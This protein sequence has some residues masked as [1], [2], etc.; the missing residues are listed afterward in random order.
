MAFAR[1]LPALVCGLGLAGCTA[2]AAFYACPEGCAAM[3]LPRDMEMINDCLCDAGVDTT[4]EEAAADALDSNEPFAC[5]GRYKPKRGA[6]A[7]QSAA[8]CDCFHPYEKDLATQECVLKSCPRAGN[9]EP[10]RGVG[11]VDSLADCTCTPPFVKVETSGQCVAGEAV[12][13]TA[14]VRGPYT[15]P[16]N[17]TPA[18]GVSPQ[19]FEDCHCTWGFV[20]NSFQEC[21]RE[22][23]AYVCPVNSAKRPDLPIHDRPR[24][25]FDC[26]CLSDD[27]YKRDE[28]AHACW[29]V[30]QIKQRKP[31]RRSSNRGAVEAEDEYQEFDVVNFDTQTFECPPFSRAVATVPHSI[32]Q[33]QCL[34][35]YAWKLPEMIC[36]R[37]SA[38]KCPEHA[39]KRTQT[40]G[41]EVEASFEDC[42]CARGYFL[43]SISQR[44]VPWML[45]NSNA[46]P[47]FAVLTQWPLQSSANCKCIYGLNETIYEEEGKARRKAEAQEVA[48]GGTVKDTPPMRHRK[49]E[50]NTRPTD[51]TSGDFSQCPHDS[52]ATTWPIAS[53]DDCACLADFEMTPLSEQEVARGVGDGFH[54]VASPEKAVLADEAAA[55]CRAPGVIHPLSGECRLP[56]EEIPAKK[57]SMKTTPEDKPEGVLF[58]GIEYDYELVDGTI[59]IIQG[60]I[61]IGERLVW[62]DK[63]PNDEDESTT[64]IEHVLHGYYNSGRDHRWPRDEL[65]FQVDKSARPFLRTIL[66]ATEHINHAT[67][68]KFHRCGG[69]NC[70]TDMRCRSHD[71]VVVQGVEASCYSFVGRIGG[72]QRLGVSADCGLGNVVHVLLHAVGLRHAVDREDR[73]EHVRIAWECVPESKR[74]YFVV[75]DM[76]LTPTPTNAADRVLDPPPYDLFSIMHHPVDAFVHSA[77]DDDKPLWCPSMIPLIKDDD[78]RLA[79]M[80]DMGQR[81]RMTTSDVKS[82]WALYPGLKKKHHDRQKSGENGEAEVEELHDSYVHTDEDTVETASTGALGSHRGFGQRLVSFLGAV[83]ML[84]GFGALLAFITTE[85][86]RR[87][88]LSSDSDY[89]YEAPLID[90]TND[91]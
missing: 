23:A 37:A 63:D 24:G 1:L 10:K 17:S 68:F 30:T 70:R 88:L 27:N 8:D 64:R 36:V 76:S 33:C 45:T 69:D 66:S 43:D 78:K 47:P 77:P 84:V 56:V 42:A 34:P 51:S 6:G 22:R 86:R 75:E 16:L 25:F 11:N 49:K 59:M 18:P 58:K 39:Y 48:N 46:C 67:G 79:V 61:A 41:I 73:D 62:E 85:L 65:C 38:Y 14:N 31:K 3:L 83:V 26:V 35:G 13:K 20:R 74:S 91:I 80:K 60:D 87:A 57:T 82:V 12:V 2:Q 52:I 90:S 19:S 89:F 29:P 40:Q 21:E 15:C 54:C 81:E 5:R 72:P 9:Y 44:C 71:F 50:C 32:E 28:E 7:A 4:K 55:A 53:P